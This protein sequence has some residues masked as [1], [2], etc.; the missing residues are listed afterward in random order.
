MRVRVTLNKLNSGRMQ[1]ACVRATNENGGI[2]VGFAL[3]PFA[4]N[5]DLEVRKVLTRLGVSNSAIADKM[6]LP[7][8]VGSEELVT[9]AA[10]DIPGDV[11]GVMDSW[12]SKTGGW[13]SPNFLS[14]IPLE[15]SGPDG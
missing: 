14:M 7:S 9:V 8:V 5:A 2:G 1:L 11:L 10:M 4:A 6:S 13:A 12:R 15:V 3:A